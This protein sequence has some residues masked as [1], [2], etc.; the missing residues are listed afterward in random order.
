VE[1]PGQADV[2][3]VA[4]GSL[5]EALILEPALR[6]TEEPAEDR[7]FFDGRELLQCQAAPALTIASTIPA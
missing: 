2:G 6:L 3:D 5:H 7:A 1:H 4:T